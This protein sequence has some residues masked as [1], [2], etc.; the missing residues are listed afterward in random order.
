M[1]D[2]K[3][4]KLPNSG[5]TFVEMI[6][7]VF[8][9]V[10][11]VGFT[12]IGFKNFAT[13]QQYNQAVG[14][15]GFVLN[16]TKVDARSSA[17]DDAHGIHVATNTITQFVGDTYNVS[18]S[19]NQEHTFELVTFEANLTGGVDTIVFEKLTGI[20]SATG[21]IVVNGR[22]LN[23]STTFSVSDSGVIQ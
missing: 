19:T 14:E 11:I 16:Q 20:P 1:F 18:D 3:L 17:D 15:V 21:T 22:D 5:F 2:L 23:A 10:L 4:S 9:I 7:V 13:Y 12:V 8:L 6:I